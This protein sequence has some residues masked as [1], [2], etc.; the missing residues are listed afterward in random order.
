MPDPAS[1]LWDQAEASPHIQFLYDLTR[2]RVVY[3]SPAYESGLGGRRAH[4]NEELPALLAR[5][6]PDDRSLWRRYWPLWQ[7]GRLRDEVEVRLL[8]PQDTEQWFCLSPHWQ[9]DAEGH[10]LLGGVLREITAE[11]QH[12]ANSDK[13]NT[14]KNTVLSLLAHDLAGAFVLLQQLIDFI[15]EEMSPQANPRVPEMLQ[16]MQRT[17]AHSVRLIYD[18]IDQEFLASAAIPLKRER[19]DLR[20][21]VAQCL[22]P[23]QRAPGAEAR[24]LVV[25]LPAAPVV[26]E[27]DTNKLLQVV[28]NLLSNAFKFTP[29]DKRVT[30][31]V[32]E[33]G[34]EAVRLQ[35]ADEGIGISAELLPQLFERFTPARRP[36][37]R[38]EPTTGLGLSLCK[39]IVELHQGTLTVQSVEGQGSTFTVE[40]PRATTSSEPS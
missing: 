13:F 21:K 19:V 35:V 26:A 14:K 9:R 34:A 20:E 16:L 39:T 25:E 30:V 10:V 5:L 7:A 38:G 4:V 17:S 31:R 28:S 8:G 2:G 22:E 18:L 1:F 37:L 12:R 27:V 6:H 11:R 32:D 40:L 24:Q 36:G 29:A 3:V 23:F 15:G 33:L